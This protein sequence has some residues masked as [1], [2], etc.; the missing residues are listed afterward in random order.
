MKVNLA[1]L[2]RSFF[3]SGYY[4]APAILHFFLLQLLMGCV[5]LS[6]AGATQK[7]VSEAIVIENDWPPYYFGKNRDTLP[8]FARELI[9]HCSS[10]AGI[11][12][13]FHFFPVKR[14]YSYLKKGEIDIAIFSYKKSREDFVYYGTE[15]LFTSGY[16]PVVLKDSG[17]TIEKMRDFDALKLGHLAGLIYSPDFLSYINQ[18]KKNNTL[19]TTTIGGATLKM[20]LEGIID[21]Y[22]DTRDTVL[23][24]AKQEDVRDRLSIIDFDIKTSNYFLTISKNT[25]RIADPK[26]V[27]D[28]FDACIKSSKD[29]GSYSTIARKYGIE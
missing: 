8:G 11:A 9:E 7:S 3:L 15:S 2:F 17:I 19:I 14:M 13:Q 10:E 27:L 25:Q 12:P 16:R 21:V 29:N 5:F 18:R 26:S 4:K 28:R 20:L 6:T 23:W 1:K 22:V 24:R